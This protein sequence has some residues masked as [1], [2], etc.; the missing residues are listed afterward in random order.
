MNDKHKSMEIEV[1]AIVKEPERL[2]A[3]LKE[4]A[5]LK[6]KFFK[7]DI[8][9]Y[10]DADENINNMLRLR[11]EHGGYVFTQKKRRMQD[12]VEINEEREMDV[13]K[14]SA[15]RFLKLLENVM[16]YSEYVRK[17]KKGRAYSYNGVLV[18]MS[19][20]VGLGH[21][22]ELE[23][24]DSDLSEDEQLALLKDT[25]KRLGL[26]EADIEQRPYVKLLRES[27]G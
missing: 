22:V 16:G 6:K 19:E 23:L 17:E 2:A 26:S 13:S 10:K 1:K 5:K 15:K 18:E 9:Y 8:Y 12:G 14:K 24:L 20:V 21:F 3:F 11:K 25:L 4:N 27:Q 7:R